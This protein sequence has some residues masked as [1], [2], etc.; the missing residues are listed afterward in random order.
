[1]VTREDAEPADGDA[2]T[3][4][5]GLGRPGVHCHSAAWQVL[6]S[7][8]D[9]A[10]ATS[11]GEDVRTQP[12][13]GPRYVDEAILRRSKSRSSGQSDAAFAA[14]TCESAKYQ[15]T[16]ARFSVMAVLEDLGGVRC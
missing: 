10:F 16:D 13:R 11:P 3:A 9:E 1:V 2:A 5:D 4:P 12:F 14:A 6:E 8:V 15:L 7:R